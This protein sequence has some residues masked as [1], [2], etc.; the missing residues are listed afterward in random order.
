[1]AQ[2]I[3]DDRAATVFSSALEKIQENVGGVEFTAAPG[4]AASFSRRAARRGVTEP[5]GTTGVVD[6]LR[7]VDN[8]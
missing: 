5:L 4:I 8:D 3:V 2:V 6:D 1:M 7:G